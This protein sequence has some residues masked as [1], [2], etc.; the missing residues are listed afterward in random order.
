MPWVKPVKSKAGER[1]GRRTDQKTR[2]HFDL[3]ELLTKW[4]L[5]KSSSASWVAGKKMTGAHCGWLGEPHML[6]GRRAGQP[7]LTCIGW[8]CVLKQ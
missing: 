5:Q 4:I 8:L 1:G 7:D 3:S 6:R 2:G